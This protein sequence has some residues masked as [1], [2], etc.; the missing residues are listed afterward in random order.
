MQIIVCQAFP[1]YERE[2]RKKGPTWVPS[3]VIVKKGPHGSL[4]LDIGLNPAAPLQVV[5]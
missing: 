1:P 3:K 5:P 4:P 2:D